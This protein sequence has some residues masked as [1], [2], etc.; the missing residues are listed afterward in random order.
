MT[1]TKRKHLLD[2]ELK[3]I[4]NRL[5]KDYRPEQIVLFGSY[6]QGNIHAWSDLDL[7][8]VKQTRKPFIARS[9]EAALA[10]RPTVGVDFL[11]YTPQELRHMRQQDQYFI[12]EIDRGKVLYDR[13]KA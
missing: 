1:V 13:S 5:T 4:V 2:N 10:A 7:M 9:I 3:R 12:R 8:V 6:A 11:V